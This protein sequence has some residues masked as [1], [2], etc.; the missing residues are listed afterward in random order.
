[1]LFPSVRGKGGE[2]E[3]GCVPERLQEVR[4][5]AGEVLPHQAA[6]YGRTHVYAR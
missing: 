1:M 2:G 6:S 5:L 3:Q 4:C